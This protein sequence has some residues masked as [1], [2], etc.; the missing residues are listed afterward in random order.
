MLGKMTNMNNVNGGDSSV[1][2]SIVEEKPDA[3]EKEITLCH[4]VTE[5]VAELRDLSKRVDELAYFTQA[6][7]TKTINKDK[8]FDLLHKELSELRA[9][10]AFEEQK[11]IIRDLLLIQDRIYNYLNGMLLDSNDCAFIGSIQGEITALLAKKDV[12]IMPK[13]I[14]ALLDP[15]KQKVINTE[16]VDSFDKNNT[17]LHVL[18]DGYLCNDVIIRFQ[19][20]IVGLYKG[21]NI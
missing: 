2:D 5:A 9:N 12:S 8:S 21:D 20:V 7:L 4:T 3:D 11:A 15:T 18:R 1:F 6:A 10:R 19:E 14:G 16:I 17:V 13:S